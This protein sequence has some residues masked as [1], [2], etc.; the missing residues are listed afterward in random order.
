MIK[1]VCI[2]ESDRVVEALVGSR[3]GRPSCLLLISSMGKPRGC[4]CLTHSSALDV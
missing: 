2:W 3:A 4:A 1:V